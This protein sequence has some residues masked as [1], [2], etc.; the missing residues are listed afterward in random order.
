MGQEK[1]TSCKGPRPWSCSF[2]IYYTVH[3]PRT[4][5]SWPNGERGRPRLGPPLSTQS[6]GNLELTSNRRHMAL[7]L[8]CRPR[9]DLFQKGGVEGIHMLVHTV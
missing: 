4:S 5:A 8:P 3:G 6:A 7:Q 2:S 1:R 9:L